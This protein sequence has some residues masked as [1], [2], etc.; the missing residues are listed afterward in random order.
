MSPVRLHVLVPDPPTPAVRAA[1]NALRLAMARLGVPLD[2]EVALVVMDDDGLRALNRQYRG[3][4]EPTDV[5]SFASDPALHIP[6]EP[7]DL[8]DI[9]VSLPVASRNAAATGWPL[10]AELRLLAVHGL[11]HLLGH[12][13]ETAA[14]AECMRE[15]EVQ[16]GVRP[17]ADL[18]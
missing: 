7:P 16:L 5:L 9:I 12:E 17:A 18:V 1:R 6:G 10:E 14:G 15:L 13:D 8:G 4:D 11:L 2:A 3:Q